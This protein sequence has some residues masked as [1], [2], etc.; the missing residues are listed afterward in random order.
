MKAILLAAVLTTLVGVVACNKAETPAETRA[1]V[2]TARTEASKDVAE[3][4]KD[5]NATIADASHDQAVANA[6]A[7]HDV[8]KA[9]ESVALAEAKA[10]HKIAIVKCETLAGDARAVCK[11]K[12]DADLE[13]ANAIAS[14]NRAATDPKP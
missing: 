11:R 5:A 8:S 3:V 4:R 12:A 2:A 10:A 14:Q 13:S 6:T 1:D 7:S 9:D